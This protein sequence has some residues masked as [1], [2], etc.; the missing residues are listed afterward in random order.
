M[1]SILICI[2]LPRR[3]DGDSECARARHD[4]SGCELHAGILQVFGPETVQRHIAR[5]QIRHGARDSF[6][7]AL[8]HIVHAIDCEP[9]NSGVAE[10]NCISLRI[11]EQVA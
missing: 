10:K 7:L 9:I 2:G 4:L 6:D 5:D 8:M 1:Q 3:L 11:E